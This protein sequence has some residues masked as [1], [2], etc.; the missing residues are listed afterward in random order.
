M[1]KPAETGE[2][3]PLRL[4]VLGCSGSIGAQTLD[5]C[6][7]HPDRVEVVALSV[8]S[9]TYRLVSA[10]HEFSVRHVAVSSKSHADDSVL[11]ELPD[12][13]ELSFGPEAVTRLSTL[14]DM[15]LS[16]ASFMAARHLHTFCSAR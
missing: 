13:G 2:T 4:A 14:P 8:N 5:V 12:G 15:G 3:R 9:S 16:C 1:T 6:R 11:A 10:A 7:Q